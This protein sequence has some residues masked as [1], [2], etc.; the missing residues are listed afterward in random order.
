MSTV[1]SGQD[2]GRQSSALIG[3]MVR[4]D[5]DQYEVTSIWRKVASILMTEESTVA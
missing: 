4:D 2:S 5:L 1:V 3:N